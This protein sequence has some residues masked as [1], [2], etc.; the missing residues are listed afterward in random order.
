MWTWWEG[1]TSNNLSCCGRALETHIHALL[2]IYSPLLKS[3]HT[4]YRTSVS[5]QHIVQN[6]ERKIKQNTQSKC[7]NKNDWLTEWMNEWVNEWT[8]NRTNR[9]LIVGVNVNTCRIFAKRHCQTRVPRWHKGSLCFVSEMSLCTCIQW[10]IYMLYRY[11]C[12][13]KS[14][15]LNLGRSNDSSWATEPILYTLNRLRKHQVCKCLSGSKRAH[16]F[17][18]VLRH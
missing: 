9:K 13:H 1:V 16:L 11:V 7:T 4:T 15:S 17:A 3:T 10:T 14:M 2:F 18:L 5:K 6:I 12:I 8:N